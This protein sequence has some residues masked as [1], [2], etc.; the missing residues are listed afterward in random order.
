VAAIYATPVTADYIAAT[1]SFWVR[2]SDSMVSRATL[3]GSGNFTANG[4]VTAYSDERLKTD[5][6]DLA[7][8]FV[9]RLAV[10]KSG[11]YTRIDN[12]LRQIGVSA[13]SLEGV[14]AEGVL[15]DA[16]GNLSVAYGNVALAAAVALSQRVIQL[17]ARLKELELKA[18]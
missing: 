4:N 16:Q 6:A 18:A 1:M 8:D 7:H 10:V 17:E 11:L 3:D 13:Q 2:S 9:E 5:W 14:A 15:R 12:G